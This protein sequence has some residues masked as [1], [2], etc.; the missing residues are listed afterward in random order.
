MYDEDDILG[1]PL[2]P[3]STGYRKAVTRDIEVNAG[4]DVNW[5]TKAWNP[6]SHTQYWN[7][8]EVVKR[9]ERRVASVLNG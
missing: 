5:L 4:P 2:Q 7:D 6:L 1:W 3:L 9:I 8:S